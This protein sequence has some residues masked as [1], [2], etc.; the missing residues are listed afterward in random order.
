MEKSV[1]LWLEVRVVRVYFELIFPVKDDMRGREDA[2]KD[3]RKG[4]Y[5]VASFASSDWLSF[6]LLTLV[7]SEVLTDTEVFLILTQLFK[8]HQSSLSLSKLTSSRRS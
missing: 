8:S 2:R 3:K 4:R 5:L 1:K 7:C 6:S